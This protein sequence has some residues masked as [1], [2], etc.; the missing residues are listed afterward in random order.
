V[1]VDD[2]PASETLLRNVRQS[3]KEIDSMITGEDDRVLCVVGPCSIHDL[4]FLKACEEF[5]KR[6]LDLSRELKEEVKICMRVY[7]EKPRTTEGLRA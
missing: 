3:R 6:L 2:Y 5:A 4:K 1:L 7:F